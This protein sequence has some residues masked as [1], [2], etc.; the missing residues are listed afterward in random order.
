MNSTGAGGKKGNGPDSGGNPLAR[1][2][3]IEHLKAM[4]EKGT[5][6]VNAKEI[7]EKM[8]EDAVR[9]I[10]SRHGSE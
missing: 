5:Y 9:A 10:R 8:V 7:A 6:R 4:V 2:K 1:R 3:R